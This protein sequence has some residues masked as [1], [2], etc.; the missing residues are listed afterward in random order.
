V[1]D[2]QLE[3]VLRSCKVSR[4]PAVLRDISVTV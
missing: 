1:R 2:G 4:L 3:L